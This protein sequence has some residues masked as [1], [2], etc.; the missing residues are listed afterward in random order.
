VKSFEIA[1]DQIVRVIGA[2]VADELARSYGRYVE[3]LTQASWRA[4]TR[5]GVEGADV[6]TEQARSC[7]R[8]AA[9]FFG[10]DDEAIALGEDDTFGDWADQVSRLIRAELTSFRF[11][12]ATHGGAADTRH[13]ADDIWQDARGVAGLMQGR[14]RVVTLVST[15]NLMGLVCGV[16]APNLQ[17]VPVMD[18]RPLTPD[19]LAGALAFGD[20]VVATPTLWRYLADTLPSV[21]G[22]VTG[23]SYGEALTPDLAERIRGRGIGAMRELYGSTETG[24]LAWRDSPSDPFVLFD[25]W[26]REEDGTVVTRL[27][28]GGGTAQ[29]LPMDELQW[30]APRSFSLGGRRDGAVQIGG[31]NVFPSK[32]AEVIAA[33]DA[34]ES[35]SVRL[36]RRPGALDRLIAHVR[37]KPGLVS[38]QDLAWSVDEWCRKRLQP[39]ERPRIYTFEEQ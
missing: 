37:L 11:H 34:V 15:G 18:A 36:S 6:T 31:I 28:A 39:P 20:M 12:P 9:I 32:I 5:L 38:D 13:G 23:I 26:Q 25:H 14:R 1:R 8:R 33:Q 30:Q 27:K 22:N 4:G 7:A 19:E 16:L 3:G 17:R 24:I 2:L 35:A 10:Q 29:V 21:P